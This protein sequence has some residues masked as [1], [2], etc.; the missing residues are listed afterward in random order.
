VIKP[1]TLASLPGS[2]LAPSGS[3]LSTTTTTKNAAVVY[4]Q[5]GAVVDLGNESFVPGKEMRRFVGVPYGATW[6]ELKLKA[7]DA[8]ATPKSYMV[9][10]T[11]LV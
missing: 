2:I 9:R 8:T 5:H 3:S 1:L 10:A 11:A 4:E 7:S 6:A